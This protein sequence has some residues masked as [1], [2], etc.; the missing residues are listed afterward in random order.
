MQAG[1]LKHHMAPLKRGT[2]LLLHHQYTFVVMTRHMWPAG[3]LISE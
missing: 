1:Q 3:D 2:G